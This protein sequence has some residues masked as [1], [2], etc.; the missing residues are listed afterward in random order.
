MSLAAAQLIASVEVCGE[1]LRLLRVAG[2]LPP[3]EAPEA[4]AA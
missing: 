1:V 2:D 4:H 3:A